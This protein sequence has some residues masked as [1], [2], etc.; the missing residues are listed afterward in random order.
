M[1]FSETFIRKPVAT[2]LLTIALALSGMIA[3]GVLPVSP[4]P[5][6]DFPTISVGTSLPGASPETMA[7]A[8]AT[9]L[10]RQFGRI[11]A[12]TEMTSTSSLGSASVTLQF[13]LDRN[14][15][16]AARDVLAGINAA[17]GQLPANLPS[18]PNY[19]KVNPSDSPIMMLALTSKTYDQGHMYDIASTILQQKLSQIQGVGQVNVG[20]S[21]LPGVR[22]ELNPGALIH[23][24]IGLEAVRTALGSVNVNQPKGYIAD[25]E[26]TWSIF[27]TDQLLKAK[28]YQP[29]LV[30]YRNGAA[31]RLSDLGEVLDSVEDLRNAGMANGKPSV[32]LMV[33][34][35]PG[36]N[37]I[38]TVDR[39]RA[40]LPWLNSTIPQSVKL[41]PLFDQT[42]TIRASVHDV[43][44]TMMIS[45]FLVIMVVFVF[46]RSPRATFIPSVVVPVSLVATF[47]VM[48]LCNYSIDNLSLMALTISTGF[49]V[50]DAIVVIENITRYLEEGMQPLAAALR[51]ARE[52][53]FTVLSMSTSLI[54]VF[55]PILLMNGIV[56]RLFREF[57][58]TLSV[59]IMMSLIVSLTTTPMMCARMLKHRDEVKHGRIYRAS[60]AVFDWILKIYSTSLM[61]MMQR[62]AFTM[63][64]LLCTIALN[65]VLIAKVPKGFF[66]QTDNGRMMG[67][68]Q[69][70]QD[71]SFQAMR[72]KTEQLINIVG[73][74]PAVQSSMGFTG[75]G[76]GRG[77]GG[78]INSGNVFVM[79]KPLEQR[80]AS[81]YEVI[82]R[83][84]RKLAAVPGAR[85]FLQASQDLRIG[86]RSSGATYQYTLRGDNLQEL[87]VWAPK[88]LAAMRE[89]PMLTEVNTDQQNYGLA[90][91]LSYDR[92]TAGRLGITSQMIDNTLYDAFGQRQVSTMYTQLNQYH[93]VMEVAPKFWQDPATL[94]QI[95]VRSNSG[96]EVPLSAFTHFERKSTALTVNHQSQFPAATISFNLAIG[97]A[98]GDAVDAINDLQHDMG[99]PATL[100]GSFQGTAL[101]FQ[102]SL[103]GEPLLIL[104]AL[105]SVYIV[106]GMLYESY[107]H[108]ITILSTLPSAGVGAILALLLCQLDLSVIAL[109]G[110]ILLIGLVKKNAILM[111]DFALVAERQE[112]LPPFEAIYKACVLRFR[113]IMMTTLAALLGGLP[114][115]LGTGYGSEMRRP[116]GITIVGGLIVSQ[117]LTLYTTPVVYLY[118]SRFGS[119]WE[120]VR[121]VRTAHAPGRRKPVVSEA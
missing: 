92:S 88:L 4:L 116:L 103:R 33:M 14:I 113:P 61:W 60:E 58:V 83:L 76:G 115:A 3:F 121:G 49:V 5:Q 16:A 11:A 90:A 93:V 32:L 44:R 91:T 2:T 15:D 82:N 34:R 79:L 85:L 22:V 62:S 25:R 27:T 70:S 57:A 106:L 86:G 101:A 38:A 8:V 102:D 9:P 109:I 26:H 80:D 54:A 66:P 112:G 31:V 72:K 94:D 69:G 95:Y 87:N 45:I 67:S 1:N 114:L 120:R 108:P 107:I 119:W 118:M 17:R 117:M 53:G 110:I 30:A 84:R 23:Y 51:G 98:L 46:L 52:I 97:T 111:I 10:E 24:G 63:L 105:V 47:G 96:P 37:I 71:I 74:D 21:A 7:S 75:G 81:V 73:T 100:R 89:L 41:T 39:V 56:G 42:T 59:A 6:I 99:F 68:I 48:Y 78:G 77:G 64:L 18:N 43:E 65:I 50:D 36:A 13:D 20:G 55:I 35:Q 19:R 40:I 29:L 28:F 104:A 12:V